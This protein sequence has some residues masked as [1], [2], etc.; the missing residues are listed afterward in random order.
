MKPTFI[1]PPPKPEKPK[2]P[3]L[4]NPLLAKMRKK[5]REKVNKYSI[6]NNQLNQEFAGD[7]TG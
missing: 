1:P 5:L 6:E 7:S 2:D 4:A 3:V